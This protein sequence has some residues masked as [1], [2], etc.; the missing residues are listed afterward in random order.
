MQPFGNWAA[1]T[2]VAWKNLNALNPKI[3]DDFILNWYD[4]QGKWKWERFI[5]RIGQFIVFDLHDAGSGLLVAKCKLPFTD[6]MY[7]HLDTKTD[8]ISVFLE[9]II[10]N[11]Y[12]GGT[13]GGV[14]RL[15]LDLSVNTFI[16]PKK[17]TEYWEQHR[18][19]HWKTFP[20]PPISTGTIRR[21]YKEVTAE[22]D[23]Q[24]VIHPCFYGFRVR[25]RGNQEDES[26]FLHPLFTGFTLTKQ[27]IAPKLARNLLPVVATRSTINVNPW[28]WDP[29]AASLGKCAV[30]TD[31]VSGCPRCF[32][33]PVHPTGVASTAEEFEFDPNLEREKL[34]RDELK[35]I[36]LLAEKSRLKL[37]EE[38]ASIAKSMETI[39]SLI[40]QVSSKVLYSLNGDKVHSRVEKEVYLHTGLT[41]FRSMRFYRNE[42]QQ[43]CKLYIKVMPA[44]YVRRFLVSEGDTVFHLYNMFNAHSNLGNSHSSMIVLPTIEGMFELRKELSHDT[45]EVLGET[46]GRDT[47]GDYGLIHKGST[48]VMLYFSNYK[49]LY[50]PS[51]LSTFFEKNT[52]FV[53][54]K[55]RT[56][57]SVEQLPQSVPDDIVQKNLKML[58]DV[59]Y[60]LQQKEVKQD[61][62]RRG[63]DYNRSAAAQL[64]L[65]AKMNKEKAK[66]RQ[67]EKLAEKLRLESQLKGLSGPERAAAKKALKAR[68]L[69]KKRS[70]LNED[71]K[72]MLDQKRLETALRSRKMLSVVADEGTAAQ[73]ESEWETTTDDDETEGSSSDASS[74]TS[75][76]IDGVDDEERIIPVDQS[77]DVD[78]EFVVDD[79]DDAPLDIDDIDVQEVDAIDLPVS[80]RSSDSA[81]RFYVEKDDSTYLSGSSLGTFQSSS[82]GEYSQDSSYYSSYNDTT[83][84]SSQYTA[85]SSQYTASSSQY[86]ASSS[87][88]TASSSQYTASSSQYSSSYHHPSRTESSD[89]TSGHHHI[90]SSSDSTASSTFLRSSSGSVTDYSS[91]A[92]TSQGSSSSS[93]GTSSNTDWSSSSQ[94]SFSE[95]EEVKEGSSVVSSSAVSSNSPPYHTNASLHSI[96]SAY[97]LDDSENKSSM[98]SLFSG[99]PVSASASMGSYSTITSIQSLSST[100]SLQSSRS[101]TASSVTRSTGGG[102]FTYRSALD[103]DF[104]ITPRT[105][106]G[107][108]SGWSTDRSFSDSNSSS[109]SS[110]A[111]SAN[112]SSYSSRASSATG[113]SY[114]SRASSATG[115]SYS[116]RASSATESN[117]SSRASSATGSS[118]SSRASSA[119]GSS[120]SSRASSATG[121]SFS[122][123]ASS[124]TGSSYSNRTS[125]ATGSSYSNSSIFSSEYS[126][127]IDGSLTNRSSL[128]YDEAV[129]PRTARSAVSRDGSEAED[130]SGP[131]RRS[132]PYYSEHVIYRH[133][134]RPVSESGLFVRRK[135]STSPTGLLQSDGNSSASYDS[136]DVDKHSS[137][138]SR[139][140]R[141]GL[142]STNSSQ[143]RVEVGTLQY[144]STSL[145]SK[146]EKLKSNRVYHHDDKSS[147]SSSH[148]TQVEDVPRYYS[149]GSEVPTELAQFAPLPKIEV[150]VKEGERDPATEEAIA[151][152]K[153]NE[154]LERRSRIIKA[155]GGDVVTRAPLRTD[156]IEIPITG[157]RDHIIIDG[158]INLDVPKIDHSDQSVLVNAAAEDEENG[159]MASNG[160]DSVGTASVGRRKS[161][162]VEQHRKQLLHASMSM[163]QEEYHQ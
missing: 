108:E 77:F 83:A 157:I 133:E 143:G 45:D 116:S 40:S 134:A 78:D 73:E 128:S 127:D 16:R 19:E 98:S 99:L 124:A 149:D 17:S 121:S 111:S 75:D 70:V 160:T 85:S 91:L 60:S 61:Y 104:T 53:L 80:A 35:L 110:R 120:Y 74:D 29:L 12:G 27:P 62:I 114:S 161:R 103:S 3:R 152:E 94:Q 37:V 22:Y 47:M 163:D 33:Y 115:S 107:Q 11:E 112:G 93:V 132:T 105:E 2:G 42:V 52:T 95:K 151:V 71:E 131:D 156:L 89:E 130:S 122:S 150:I 118:Y 38:V 142:G 155:G 100:S 144:G 56:F 24:T 137:L 102:L 106:G 44:G 72:L 20:V 123:R 76:S 51:L 96:Y 64:E 135:G 119:T 15:H 139:S 90:H 141:E 31:G 129:T 32:M 146:F 14:A 18:I 159:S 26:R 46:R 67:K 63:I 25:W 5:L 109:Y 28:R 39:G 65:T 68:D 136:N 55:L 82:Y 97:T 49:P 6:I 36:S 154:T 145:R 148:H 126:I 158:S 138:G 30:C 69:L 23:R 140:L 147:K 48:V 66:Q 13:I 50:V 92:T 153:K 21:K 1:E 41:N 101:S 59:E 79:D 86:T 4:L 7:K 10:A 34:R 88:Y 87:Q 113:S 117:Y 84:S 162:F 8:I 54:P 57:N 125:S 58:I 9:F 81:S 43:L